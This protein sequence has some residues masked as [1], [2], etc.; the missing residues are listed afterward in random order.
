MSQVID[1]LIKRDKRLHGLYHLSS[2]PIDKNRLL[3]LI[4]LKAERRVEI[5]PVDEP[6]ID[7]S[8]DSSRL[9]EEIELDI[10]PWEVLIED[11]FVDFDKYE[12][13]QSR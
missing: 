11:L 2:H 3:N 7:R 6:I 4:N 13:L 9:R 8:L 12:S 1:Q 5:D 10:E